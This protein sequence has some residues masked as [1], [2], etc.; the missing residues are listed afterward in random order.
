MLSK[1]GE[2]VTDR[3]LLF[4][5]SSV[6]S[7]PFC[8]VR[9]C[10]R[11]SAVFR[12]FV[13][14]LLSLSLSLVL[15]LP[16]R[17]RGGAHSFTRRVLRPRSPPTS[18]QACNTSVSHSVCNALC[19]FSHNRCSFVHSTCASPQRSHTRSSRPLRIRIHR[20]TV[21]SHRSRPAPRALVPSPLTVVSQPKPHHVCVLL[22][23][24][25][26]VTP[27]RHRSIRA[28]RTAG[29]PGAA[30]PGADGAT[31]GTHRNGQCV[32]AFKL[33]TQATTNEPLHWAHGQRRFRN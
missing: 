4:P 29:T 19:T 9:F 23:A 16:F 8:V 32:W 21:V 1:G 13:A 18:T 10:I 20:F 3:L 28:H 31:G 17:P 25:V 27:G 30:T 6:V 11:F 2:D 7:F 12:R 5:L 15:S 24:P 26:L 22:P 33:P 14:R